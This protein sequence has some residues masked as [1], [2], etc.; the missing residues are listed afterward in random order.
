[1][2]D[3]DESMLTEITRTAG[4]ISALESDLSELM[5]EAAENG[6]TWAEINDAMMKGM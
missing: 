1:M 2:T 3:R 4:R 6:F 5:H